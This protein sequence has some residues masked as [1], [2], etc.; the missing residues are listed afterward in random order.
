MGDPGGPD[1]KMGPLIS[2]EH[3]EKVKGYIDLAR[4]EGANILCGEGVDE[5]ALPEKNKNV[6]GVFLY[7]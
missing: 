7:M 1:T 6:S 4:Q 2:R 5:L 3:K